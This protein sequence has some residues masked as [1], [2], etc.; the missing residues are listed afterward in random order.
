MLAGRAIVFARCA[1][2]ANV[3]VRGNRVARSAVGGGAAAR[4]APDAAPRHSIGRA[5][6]R[7]RGWPVPVLATVAN[8]QRSRADRLSR[9]LQC[10][11]I[12]HWIKAERLTDAGLVARVR[13]SDGATERLM[14]DGAHEL[15]MRR[16]GRGILAAAV[17][18]GARLDAARSSAGQLLQKRH[19]VRSR[20]HIPSATVARSP[21]TASDKGRRGSVASIP[22]RGAAMAIPTQ[23]CPGLDCTMRM[24]ICALSMSPALRR[25]ISPHADRSHSQARAS[26]EPSGCRP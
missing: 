1:L 10:V 15:I 18:D 12:S 17:W 26:R 16:F 14:E 8:G 11:R 2:V 19:G 24:M 21:E 20:S 6:Q 25:T 23:P 7:I 3:N 9:V 22:W 5:H 13:R 4:L